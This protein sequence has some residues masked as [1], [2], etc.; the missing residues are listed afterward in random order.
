MSTYGTSVEVVLDAEDNGLVWRD[1]LDLVPPLAGNLDTGLDGL[2]TGVHGQD[3]VVAEILGDELG[4][5]GEDIVVEGPGAESEGCGLLGQGLDELRVAVA[6]V[7]GGVG[8]QE[9]EIVLPLG[10]PD[11]GA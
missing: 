4:E 7:D 6:L 5:L 2:S 8:G 9:V 10:V 1:A 3:H 11:G